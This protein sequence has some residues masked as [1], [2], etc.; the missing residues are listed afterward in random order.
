M[1]ICCGRVSS[2][3]TFHSAWTLM[4]AGALLVDL[5]QRRAV[6][7]DLAAEREVRPLDLVE[8]L[9]RRVASG[10]SIRQHARR[11][12][13]R[14]GCAAGCSSPCRRRCPTVPL[15]SRFGNCAGSTTGSRA[16]AVVVGPQV[17]RLLVE[18]A[19]QRLGGAG[20]LRLGV[21]V[22]GRRVAV[23]G[24]EVALPVDERHAHAPSPAPCAPARRRRRRRRAG[25]SCPSRRRRSWRTSRPCGRTS[26]CRSW[27]IAYRM[28]RCTG[29]RPSRTSGRARPVTTDIAYVRNRVRTSDAMETVSIDSAITAVPAARDLSV[30]CSRRIN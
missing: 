23:D 9:R 17:D 21:A 12:A 2:S 25:G 19:Q 28:R 18:F 30:Y 1:T 5:A 26:G 13:L 6:G 16:R 20:E 27:Y 7:D 22:G 24:A 14:R 10:L 15:T 4:R 8:Q 29:L 11:A 3:S